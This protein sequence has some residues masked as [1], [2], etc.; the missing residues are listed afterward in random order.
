MQQH[1]T[2]ITQSIVI[3]CKLLQTEFIHDI[4][5]SFISLKVIHLTSKICNPIL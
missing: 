2:E 3:Y 5:K 4:F 1:F